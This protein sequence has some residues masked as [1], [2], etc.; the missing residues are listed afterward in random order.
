MRVVALG[1]CVESLASVV[2]FFC[3]WFSGMRT[4]GGN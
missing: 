4:G 2:Q 1:P 3:A